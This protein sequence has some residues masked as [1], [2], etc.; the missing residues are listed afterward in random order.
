LSHIPSPFCSGHFE[1]GVSLFAQAGL[2]HD[3]LILRF[4]P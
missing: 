3:P 4:L 1:D 2:D